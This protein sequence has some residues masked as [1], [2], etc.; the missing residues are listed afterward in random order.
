MGLDELIE[1]LGGLRSVED[2]RDSM[3]RIDKIEYE[4]K[5]NFTARYEFHTD[6]GQ[7]EI[8]VMFSFSNEPIGRWETRSVDGGSYSDWEEIERIAVLP[9]SSV[10]KILGD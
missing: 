8:E 7:T 3:L 4:D 10:E 5:Y 9:Y 2:I 6:W 1:Y